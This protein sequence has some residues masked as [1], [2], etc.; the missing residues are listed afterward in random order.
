MR[1]APGS[2]SLLSDN[3]ADRI[4]NQWNKEK[5]E[6]EQ[7]ELQELFTEEEYTSARASIINAHYTS[8]P[9][10]RWMWDATKRLGFHGGKVLE[11]GVGIGNFFSV[12]PLETKGVS[13]LTGVEMDDLSGRIAKQLYERADVRIT[14]YQKT[15][16]PDGYFDIGDF[17]RALC[18]CPNPRQGL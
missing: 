14:P 4:F 5:W 2:D 17:Q 13:K 11:P 6:S 7:S 9:V 10:I 3:E 15:R 18:R 12:M 16:L 1:S 8:L